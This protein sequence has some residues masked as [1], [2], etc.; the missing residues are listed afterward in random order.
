LTFVLL[1]AASGPPAQKQS[2]RLKPILR[3]VDHILIESRDPAALFAFFAETLQLPVAWPMADYPG[4]SSGGVSAGN[5]HLEVLRFAAGSEPAPAKR[6]AARLIGLALEP[7]RLEDCLAEMRLRG[8][9]YDPPEPTISKLP[10]GSEGTL[11]TTVGLPA[12][13]KPELVVFLCEY[14]SAFLHAEIR[15]NQ[16]GGQLALRGGGPLGIKAVKE[17]V[18]GATDAAKWRSEWERL[19]VE[20]AT[21]STTLRIG[22]GPALRLVPG[23]ANRIQ[24]VVMRVERLEAARAFL[25]K[26]GLLGSASAGEIAIAPGK[27]QGLSV[28]LSEK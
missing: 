2:P 15:R 8:I 9:P 19:S 28:R 21:S 22:N 10:D 18:I 5:V 24:R 20:A 17:I 6:S 4:F 3:Q 25:A 16:L 11:W 12:L 27:I 26:N 7:L 23:S 1:A 13:S 14:N